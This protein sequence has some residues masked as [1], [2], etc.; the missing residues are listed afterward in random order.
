M[1][2]RNLLSFTII[3][4]ILI[5]IKWHQTIVNAEQSNETTANFSLPLN[6]QEPDTNGT[7]ISRKGQ[8]KSIDIKNDNQTIVNNGNDNEGKLLINF[9]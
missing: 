9:D 2:N 6:E 5:N 7:I 3:Y 8:E 4:L 1:S